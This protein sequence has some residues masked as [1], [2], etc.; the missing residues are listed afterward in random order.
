MLC[1]AL[2]EGAVEQTLSVVPLQ[3]QIG[4]C[5]GNYKVMVLEKRLIHFKMALKSLFTFGASL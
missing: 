1:Q 5:A 3:S 2:N 4:V